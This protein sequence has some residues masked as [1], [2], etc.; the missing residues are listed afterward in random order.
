MYRVFNLIL[1]VQEVLEYGGLVRN[2][3]VACLW[4]MSSGN[5][6]EPTT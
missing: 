2:N 1:A 5:V 6:N 4:N 3:G